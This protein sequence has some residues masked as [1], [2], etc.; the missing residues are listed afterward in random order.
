MTCQ[1]KQK[2]SDMTTSERTQILENKGIM[3]IIKSLPESKNYIEFMN[4]E[5]LKN[6]FPVFTA[7]NYKWQT[8]E[9]KAMLLFDCHFGAKSLDKELA[10]SNLDRFVYVLN[11][12]K[13]ID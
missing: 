4:D 12:Y 13:T 8:K 5:D 2:P 9:Y 1:T 3:S 7:R 11:H 6:P 10:Q